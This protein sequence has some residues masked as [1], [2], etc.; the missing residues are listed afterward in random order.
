M[1]VEQ[2]DEVA[3]QKQSY[4]SKWYAQSLS[5]SKVVYGRDE[6][7]ADTI[8]I[9]NLYPKAKDYQKVFGLKDYVLIQKL[10]VVMLK[11][12]ATGMSTL[13]RRVKYVKK[14]DFLELEKTIIEMEHGIKSDSNLLFLQLTNFGK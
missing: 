4:M 6:D 7:P 14:S 1:E 10:F 5:S 2:A 9:R 3:L 13:K 12:F 8:I 11:L